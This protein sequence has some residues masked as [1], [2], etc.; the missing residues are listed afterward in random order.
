MSLHS[1]SPYPEIQTLPKIV[2]FEHSQIALVSRIPIQEGLDF[3]AALR[4][5]GNDIKEFVRQDREPIGTSEKYNKLQKKILEN[6]KFTQIFEKININFDSNLSNFHELITKLI[7]SCLPN[8]DHIPSSDKILKFKANPLGENEVT[9]HTPDYPVMQVKIEDLNTNK[10]KN[11]IM[12]TTQKSIQIFT[13]QSSIPFFI[14]INNWKIL[15]TPLTEKS[16]NIWSLPSWSWESPMKIST[17]LLTLDSFFSALEKTENFV[18]KHKF[19]KIES[20]SG[21]LEQFL[22]RDTAGVTVSYLINDMLEPSGF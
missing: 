9:Y 17:A 1:I 13:V 10:Q 22:S 8:L 16:A 3:L 21:V 6:R 4:S 11:A 5:Y 20:R 14:R 18:K 12:L 19:K 2:E 7:L 15:E